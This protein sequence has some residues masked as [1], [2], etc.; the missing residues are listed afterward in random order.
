M[1]ST[2]STTSTTSIPGYVAGTWNADPVHSDISFAVRHMMVSKV[3]GTFKSFETTIVTAE[4]PLDSTVTASIDMSS[5]DTG[6]AGR[7]AHLRGEDFFSVETH[8]KA[9]FESTAVRPAGDDYEVDG[10]LT[11]HGVTK[12]VTLKVEANGFT[13]D[14]W[15]G[16]RSGFTATTEI[17]RKDFGIEFNIPLEGGGVV[18]GDKVQVN[19]EIEAVLQAPSA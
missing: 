6:D 11:L 16:T 9:T 4:N 1:S 8:P 5:I 15:G 10:N 3:R 2:P 18:V 12:P 19:I 14:P 17:N 13:T 7:D